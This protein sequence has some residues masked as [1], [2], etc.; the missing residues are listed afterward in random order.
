MD[1]LPDTELAAMVAIGTAVIETVTKEMYI[2]RVGRQRRAAVTES[3][4]TGANI[5][6]NN[7]TILL[8]SVTM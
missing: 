5:A 7:N 3:R 6:C 2:L 4:L 8:T 1:T